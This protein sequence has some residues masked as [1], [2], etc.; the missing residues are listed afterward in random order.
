MCKRGHR[1]LSCGEK[2]A[3]IQVDLMAQLPVTRL[4]LFISERDH[5]INAY[6]AAGGNITSKQRDTDEKKGD[7]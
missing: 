1:K 7:T 5:G 3:L 4:G 6:G 2:A